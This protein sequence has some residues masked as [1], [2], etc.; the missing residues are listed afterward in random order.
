MKERKE[1]AYLRR[2]KLKNGVE[3]LY[4]DYVY[5]GT[6]FK[7]YL[8]LYVREEKSESDKEANKEVMNTANALLA[9]KIVE[10]H[11]K[12]AGF[13]GRNNNILLEEFLLERQGKYEQ[14]GHY[15]Y[16]RNLKVLRGW[17]AKMKKRVTVRGIDAEYVTSFVS[18]LR[19][20]GMGEGSVFTMY[21]ALGCQLAAAVRSGI[22]RTHPYSMLDRMQKPKRQ[23]S[24]REYL[25]F[26]EIKAF[27]SVAPRDSKY[28]ACQKA[29]LFS[30]FTGLRLS[31][32]ENLTWDN[33]RE[34]MTGK[35][36]V[37]KQQK[38]QNVVYIPLA[39]NALSLLPEKGSESNVW[40][41]PRRCTLGNILKK[42]ASLAGISKKVTFHVAR[43]S[44]ATLA[45]TSGVD[46]YTVSKLMGHTNV[47]TTAIYAK[48]TDR[49]RRSAIDMM[50]KL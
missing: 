50:P 14:E 15:G 18:K 36:I 47:T 4:I 16:V 25:S 21:Q 44:F 32:V 5:N 43:H 13:R 35:E 30:C 23:E 31:D 38:T 26:D 20:S 33:I 45:L 48:M 29:F 40:N 3:S 19:E 10:I 6:R 22:I 9:K 34:S 27:A 42:T 7:D 1:T 46:I 28:E 8:K 37:L 49:K 24:T 39:E 12:E 17:V 11:D 2:K 41:L